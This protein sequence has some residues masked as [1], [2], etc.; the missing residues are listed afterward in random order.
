M[1]GHPRIFLFPLP[2]GGATQEF[3]LEAEE[4]LARFIREFVEDILSLPAD[5][6]F[7]LKGII[8]A[9]EEQDDTATEIVIRQNIP[10]IV[11]YIRLALA[12]TAFDQ[13][14]GVCTRH[15]TRPDLCRDFSVDTCGLSKIS[16]P[17]QKSDGIH[18]T[19]SELVESNRRFQ[20]AALPTIEEVMDA[21][22]TKLKTID[23]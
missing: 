3:I 10:F 8:L 7:S 19:I 17:K 5:R 11:L 14:T 1:V 23:F 2:R 9:T 4:V 13:P 16:R 15:D 20:A 6:R 18:Y 12:C 22:R 21:L